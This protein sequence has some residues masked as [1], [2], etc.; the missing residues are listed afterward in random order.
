MSILIYE[1]KK[2]IITFF[3]KGKKIYIITLKIAPKIKFRQYIYAN[4]AISDILLI[5]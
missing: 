3:V 4:L 1:S 5:C 2:V